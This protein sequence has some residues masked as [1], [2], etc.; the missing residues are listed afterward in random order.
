MRSSFIPRALGVTLGLVLAACS[1]AS[2]DAAG[3]AETPPGGEPGTNLDG[4]PK[5]GTGTGNGNAN[6]APTVPKLALTAP[7]DVVLGR[8]GPI[9][10]AVSGTRTGAVGAVTLRI[11]GLTAGFTSDPVTVG[12]SET[13]AFL[14]V[15]ASDAASD[16]PLTATLE[17]KAGALTATSPLAIRAPKAQSDD[18]FGKAGA[19]RVPGI[20]LSDA[21]PLPDGKL[22]AYG[23]SVITWDKAV[24]RRFLADG[25][26]DSSF[27]T[28]GIFQLPDLPASYNMTAGGL[29]AKG[30]GSAYATIGVD[31]A[32]IPTQLVVAHVLANGTLDTAFGDAGFAKITFDGGGGAPRALFVQPDGKLLVA[33]TGPNGVLFARLMPAGQLDV[34][35]GVGGKRATS[36]GAANAYAQ[37]VRSFGCKIYAFG[38]GPT[39]GGALFK[40][41]LAR[42]DDTGALDP[43]FASGGIATTDYEIANIEPTPAGN[44]LVT[45]PKY[46]QQLTSSGDKDTSF[47][48][49]S[50]LLNVSPLS[51]AGYAMDRYAIGVSASGRISTFIGSVSHDRLELWSFDAIGQRVTT[52]AGAGSILLDTPGENPLPLALRQTADGRFVGVGRSVGYPAESVLVRFVP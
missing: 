45:G 2:S 35:F 3:G 25:S 22:L 52:F 14:T 18:S 41:Y 11:T 37:G 51:G 10:I 5:D 46:V 40:G 6:V 33:G 24:L 8:G 32:S 39:A 4:T 44:W 34:S 27:G 19:V 21:L 16:A 30:D 13:S 12:A 7:S 28:N 20:T 1:G 48:A 31:Y 29:T 9:Q 49:S 36:F 38:R 26:V 17:G 23:T 42:L 47:G 43:S 15:R 50:Y